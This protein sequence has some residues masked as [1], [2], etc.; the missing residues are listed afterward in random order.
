MLM[1]PG[2][3]KPITKVLVID[4]GLRI[5]QTLLKMDSYE[6]LTN[7]FKQAI[8]LTKDVLGMCGP[9]HKSTRGPHLYTVIVLSAGKS[10][11]IS[12]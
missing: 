2:I 1:R 5:N 10:L 9:R 4:I 12:T 3:A 7:T 8:A 11:I 6:I